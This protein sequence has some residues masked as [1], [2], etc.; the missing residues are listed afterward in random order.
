MKSLKGFP[1]LMLTLERP[2]SKKKPNN[3]GKKELARLRENP[4]NPN[5]KNNGSQAHKARKWALRKA[6]EPKGAQRKK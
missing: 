2:N 4:L 3:I 5:S 1:L 6:S